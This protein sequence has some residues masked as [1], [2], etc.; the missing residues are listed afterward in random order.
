MKSEIMKGKF[1]M[2]MKPRTITHWTIKITWS[3]GEEEYLNDI[4]NW[5]AVPTD[6]YLTT[7]EEESNHGIK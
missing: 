2:R 1:D 3:D 7:L 4:P 5:V 6:E